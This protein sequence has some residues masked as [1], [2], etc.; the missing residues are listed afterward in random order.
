MC[1]NS[2]ADSYWQSLEI[3]RV[4]PCP[5]G[6]PSS[7]LAHRIP[8]TKR[9]KKHYGEAVIHHELNLV[10]VCCLE[11]NDAQSISNHPVERSR[12][13]VLVYEDLIK[14]ERSRA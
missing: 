1:R 5:C 2:K 9:N 7:Q 11:C 6:K 10:P 14:L 13:L 4:I 3:S 8:Q 12:L